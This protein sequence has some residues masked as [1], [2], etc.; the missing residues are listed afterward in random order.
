MLFLFYVLR[1]LR[2]R[3]RAN[4]VTTLAIALF[5]AGGTL[6]LAFYRSLAH[7]LVETTPRENILVLSKNAPVEGGSKLEIETAR[8]LALLD[9]IATADGGPVATRE[10]VSRV[11][12]NSADF[13]RYHDPVPIRGIDVQSFNAHRATL[14]A[15]SAPEAGSL[16]IILG[17]RV[18]AR[19]PS[20]KLGEDIVLPGGPSK[21][22]GVFAA[23]GGPHE[24]EVWTLRPALEVHVKTKFSSSVTL[25][26]SDVGQVPKLIDQ[27]NNSKELNAQAVQVAA[28]REDRAGLGTV[29]RTV[30]VL[31]VLLSIVATSAIA[32]TMNAAVVIKLPEF[33]SMAAIGI[34]RGSL[35]RIVLLESV[36]LAM[37]GA[38]VGVLTAEVLRRQV[39]DVTLGVNPVEISTS[40]MIVLV[41]LGLG[42]LVGLL[43]GIVPALKVA[44]VDIMR[45]AR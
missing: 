45:A 16:Q 42:L 33:A 12:L 19:Y 40:P 15:G 1:S 37:L 22:S 7:M 30:L 18:A 21:I 36:L 43:G 6:G 24:D 8:K 29:A 11:Y 34:R 31:L 27:I 23:G 5:V 3:I 14:V 44:R 35:A 2:A 25:V 39:G 26:A 10:L 41:G 13:S 28:F 38:I 32:T 17:R 20:L 9:G 4:A